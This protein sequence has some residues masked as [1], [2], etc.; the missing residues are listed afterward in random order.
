M[1]GDCD[2]GTLIPENSLL[3][4]VH[5]NLETPV[6]GIYV[7]NQAMARRFFSRAYRGLSRRQGLGPVPVAGLSHVDAGNGSRCGKDKGQCYKPS[8][9]N[10]WEASAAPVA[11]A[12]SAFPHIPRPK[13]A[14]LG[15]AVSPA[16]EADLQ[17]AH[18]C[19]SRYG[20]QARKQTS[21]GTDQLTRP[22]VPVG[23]LERWA[24][25]NPFG[26]LHAT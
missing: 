5:F 24:L 9:G 19:L 7:C 4:A 12:K 6:P 22:W 11:P 23:S 16:G 2:E 20:Y 18:F 21:P 14:A 1:F 8:H 25:G 10:F 26:E 15:P 13:P 17:L 3:V